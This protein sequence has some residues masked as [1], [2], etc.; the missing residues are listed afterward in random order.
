MSTEIE[1]GVD[2]AKI[3]RHYPYQDYHEVALTAA[4]NTY[5]T[6]AFYI[7]GTNM[8]APGTWGAKNVMLWGDG[9]FFVSFNLPTPNAP[10]GLPLLIRIPAN[11]Y[12]VYHPHDANI[13]YFC[14][15][16]AVNVRVW[17]EG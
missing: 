10:L 12:F 8:G 7:V 2:Y 14:A 11:V 1:G 5:L 6:A 9:D 15:L 13:I 4:N 3:K 16:G 17:M